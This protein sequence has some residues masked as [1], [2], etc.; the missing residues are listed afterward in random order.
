MPHVLKINVLSGKEPVPIDLGRQIT[1]QPIGQMNV[2]P[3][4]EKSIITGLH[5]QSIQQN[6][7]TGFES[8]G[9]LVKRNPSNE[10]V[11]RGNGSMHSGTN[12]NRSV[13]NGT[14]VYGTFDNGINGNGTFDKGINGNGKNDYGTNEYGTMGNGTN[15]VVTDS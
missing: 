3:V 4:E 13:E 7:N 6:P 8:T 5:L 1:G 2:S 10:N 12:E 14:N 11:T 9:P 15:Q